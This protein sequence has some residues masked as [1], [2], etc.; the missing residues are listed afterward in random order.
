MY[1]SINKKWRFVVDILMIILGTLVMG[2]A[3]SV[4]LTP[5]NISTGGFSGLS[6]IVSVLLG[7]IGIDWLST[8]VIY[9]IL[10]VGLFLYALKALGKTFA[11]KAIIGIVSYSLGMELFEI[12]PITLDL[13]I[14]VSAIYGGALMGV[15]LGLVVR[16]GGST[17]GSDM[18][19]CVVKNK[20]PR[21]SIGSIV[22]V[23]DMAVVIMS[24]F[25]FSGGLGLVPYTLIALC[26][27][28]YATDFVNEGYRQVRAFNIVTAKPEEVS[29]VIMQK[30]SRGCT[31]TKV[32]GMHTKVEKYNVLCL[33]S[34]FQTNYLR[35]IL[36]EV[37]DTAFV[38]SVPVSEV[39][40]EWTKESELPAEERKREHRNIAPR[41]AK[42]VAS[43]KENNEKSKANTSV[44]NDTKIA[45]NSIHNSSDNVEK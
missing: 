38:Y 16:F 1:N 28:L 20:F 13:E 45:E 4:F 27:S 3:F 2:F 9:L 33:V 40:G 10:N 43:R 26:I 36:K 35:R 30:L 25:V 7:K 29:A 41:D 24:I 31:V 37:D 17:G 39:I 18:I 23:V 21:F 34:K 5:H 11:I 22:V 14:L 15:G 8:S 12:I 42:K 6:M 44:S 19:A 32:V